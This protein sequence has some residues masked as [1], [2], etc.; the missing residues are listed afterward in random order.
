MT[1]T[2]P[3]SLDLD[4][5]LDST[6]QR[7]KSWSPT[8]ALAV[9]LF[10]ETD[11]RWAVARH[12]RLHVPKRLGATELSPGLRQALTEGRLSTSPTCPRSGEV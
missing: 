7:M 1:Q 12:R 10:D 9:L 2:L 4:D 8:T 11:G 6:L 5:V 3:A